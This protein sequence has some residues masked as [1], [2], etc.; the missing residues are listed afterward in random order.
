MTELKTTAPEVSNSK[1]GE[2]R[3]NNGLTPQAPEAGLKGFAPKPSL[4]QKV[5]SLPQKRSHDE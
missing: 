3:T 1:S 4:V 5:R 2:G